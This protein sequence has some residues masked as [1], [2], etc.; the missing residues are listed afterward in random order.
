MAGLGIFHTK[1]IHLS[2]LSWTEYVRYSTSAKLHPYTLTMHQCKLY[3]VFFGMLNSILGLHMS[4]NKGF[5]APSLI[6]TMVI[7]I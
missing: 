5:R 4:V 2:E 1:N 7:D 3:Q 6:V